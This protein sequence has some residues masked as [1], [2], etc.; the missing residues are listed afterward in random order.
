MQRI[1]TRDEAAHIVEQDIIKMAGAIRNR[2]L[3]DGMTDLDE[4]LEHDAVRFW[5]ASARRTLNATKE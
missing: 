1:F 5:L 3:I 4:I 2:I